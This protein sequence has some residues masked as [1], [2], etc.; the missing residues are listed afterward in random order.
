[1]EMWEG[2]A[3]VVDHFTGWWIEEPAPEQDKDVV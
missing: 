1:M 2:R 3:Y